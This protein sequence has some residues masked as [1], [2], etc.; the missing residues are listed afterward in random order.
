MEHVEGRSLAEWAERAPLPAE[1]VARLGAALATALHALHLQDA[2][3][4]DVKPSNVMVRPSR[5]GGAHRLRARAPRP[6]PGPPRGGVPPAHRLGALHLARA[7]ARRPLRPA[8]RR[9]RAR[10]DPRT[11]S[12]PAACR[13][14][15][16]TAPGCAG[17][18]SATP[19]STRAGA[20]CPGVVAGGDPPLPRAW[21]RALATPPRRRSRSTSRTPVRWRSASAAAAAPRGPGAGRCAAGSGRSGSSRADVRSPPYS[22]PRRRSCSRPRDA[23]PDAAQAEAIREAVRRVVRRRRRALPARR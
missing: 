20:G 14:A 1:E 9:V 15:R 22:W 17:G 18:S 2:I 11:S 4:L 16:R 10:G 13:S 7:G 3:H 8:E 21:T 19:A 6:L 12:P 23:P 5:R